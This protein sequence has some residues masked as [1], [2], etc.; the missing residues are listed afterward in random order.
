MFVVSE[1]TQEPFMSK[2][3]VF[4]VV[5]LCLIDGHTIL[6]YELLRDL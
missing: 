4:V 2:G 5:K 3:Y 6:D 1:N